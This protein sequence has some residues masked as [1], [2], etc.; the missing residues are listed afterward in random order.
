MTAI[1][2]DTETTGRNE[3]VLIEAAWVETPD[4]HTLDVTR[5]FC[6]RYNPGKPIET[7]ALAT[8]HILDEELADCPPADTFRL[9]D[10]VDFLVGHSV[11]YDWEV[12]RKPD[13]KRICTYAMAKK[14]WPDAD[15]LSQSALMYRLASDRVKVRDALKEAH[16]ALADIRF[17]R[18]ILKQIIRQVQPDSWEALWKFSEQARV[19]ESMPFGKHRGVAIGAL[20]KD[21]VRWALGN[22]TDMDPYLRKALEAA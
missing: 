2:F 5:K 15:S 3:P 11:D 7:G 8:H 10:G 9:P 21:Y 20:P 18:F 1:I 14:I 22:L 4:L 13:V 16:S 12:I 19:P 6:Q 17:C